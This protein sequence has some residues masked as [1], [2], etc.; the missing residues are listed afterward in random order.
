MVGS[1]PKAL[2][3]PRGTTGS[4]F[5]V[6]LRQGSG[7][8]GSLGPNANVSN[9]VVVHQA[10]SN[11]SNGND[12]LNMNPSDATWTTPA[13]AVG[14]KFTDPISG[15]SITVNSASPTGASVSVA[16]GGSSPTRSTTSPIRARSRTT[17]TC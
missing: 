11:D 2:K 8:D 16:L 4:Y 3:I 1:N 15:L 7:F 6:E 12:L 5:Y 9:G 10:S 13:L 14:R 17:S